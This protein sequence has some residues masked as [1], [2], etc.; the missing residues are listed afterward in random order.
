MANLDDLRKQIEGLRADYAALTGRPAALFDV[1][2]IDQANA[3]IQSLEDGID[4][5]QRKAADLEAG[6]GGIYDQLKAITSELGKQPK[7][8]EKVNRAYK[9]IQGIA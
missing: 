9:G 7:E 3:A 5:A 6:F 1:N 2:N 8:S 4:A